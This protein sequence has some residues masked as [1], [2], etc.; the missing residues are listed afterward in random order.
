MFK[1]NKYMI[2]MLNMCRIT[3]WVY[4]HYNHDGAKVLLLSWIP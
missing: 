3:T 4:L 2:L 1:S